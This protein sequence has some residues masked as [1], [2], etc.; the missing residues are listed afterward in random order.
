MRQQLLMP[1]LRYVSIRQH[2]SAYVSIHEHTYVSIRQHASATVDATPAI[3]DFLFEVVA[4]FFVAV[5]CKY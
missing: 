4:R 5:V 2:K 3:R 1:R